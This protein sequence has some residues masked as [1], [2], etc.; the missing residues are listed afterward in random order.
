MKVAEATCAEGESIYNMPVEI[1]AENVYAA[2]LGADAIGRF[3]KEA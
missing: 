1:T 2:I 3:Y